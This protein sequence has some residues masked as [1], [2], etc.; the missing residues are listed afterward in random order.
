MQ[1]R[2]ITPALADQSVPA[3]PF[4]LPRALCRP[5]ALRPGS[6][7]AALICVMALS[8]VT[9]L[10]KVP[11]WLHSDWQITPQAILQD[12]VPMRRVLSADDKTLYRDILQAQ[13]AKNWQEADLL[14]AKLNNPLLRPTLLAQRWLEDKNQE[15]DAEALRLWLARN[16]NHPYYPHIQSLA[17]RLHPSLFPAYEG[18]LPTAALALQLRPGAVASEPSLRYGATFRALV[19]LSNKDRAAAEAAIADFQ[20]SMSQGNKSAALSQ[21]D[22]NAQKMS[23]AAT[24]AFR[25]QQANILFSYGDMASALRYAAP[26]ANRSGASQP[27]MHWVA[28]MAAWEQS[29]FM[30][31]RH[32]F[33]SMAQG[34]AKLP[35]GDAAAAH[36]WAARAWDMTGKPQEALI[37]RKYAATYGESF[38]AH[39][40]REQLGQP[41][42]ATAE[43]LRNHTRLMASGYLDH[44]WGMQHPGALRA[45]A[46][47]QLGQKSLAQWEL[48]QSFQSSTNNDDRAVLAHLAGVLNMPR[49]Q[50]A[51][52]RQ[53]PRQYARL[54]SY[55]IPS[56][57]PQNGFEVDKSLLLGIARQESGF[58]ANATSPAGASGLMQ[59]MPETARYVARMAQ[60][61]IASKA[62]FEQMGAAQLASL[63]PASGGNGKLSD[64]ETSLTLGQHYLQYLAEKPYVDH[65]LILLIAAYNAGPKAAIQ[66]SNRIEDGNGDPLAFIERISYSET[67][68]YV[69]HV[70]ANS[71]TYHQLMG[72]ARPSSLRLLAKSDWP[73][74]KDNRSWF[75]YRAEKNAQESETAQL[76]SKKPKQLASVQ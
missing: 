31:A 27:A 30:R 8:L 58:D 28:G 4:A 12:A 19:H 33:H 60:K 53:L 40:A 10:P 21:A 63:Q 11:G 15:P 36:F 69:Q 32:H 38:Y 62:E 70:L 14:I 22:R 43:R 20:Q 59:L 66:W 1:Q 49:L 52:A 37:L 16:D 25:W 51:M 55:P 73:H 42:T 24:D 26:A 54:G 44:V 50:L 2:P 35:A 34:A 65:N 23:A 47:H 61:S 13:R 74:L 5:R 56:W 72:D 57:K 71:W 6:N 76:G 39:L 46:W 48:S 64:P 29:L 75:A 68:A 41:V 3:Q 17:H 9:V 18:S 7:R 67:R 45:I